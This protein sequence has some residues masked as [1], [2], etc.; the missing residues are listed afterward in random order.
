MDSSVL[1]I[2]NRRNILNS[3]YELNDADEIETIENIF[4]GVTP[5]VSFKVFF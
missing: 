1:N 4:L 5:N 3:Y 2:L